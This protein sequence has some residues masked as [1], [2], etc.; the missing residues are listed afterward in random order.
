MIKA[1]VL[2]NI[3]A[4]KEKEVISRI[5]GVEGVKEVDLAFGKYDIIIR[6]EAVDEG[7]LRSAV[8]DSIRNIPDVLSTLT[9]ITYNI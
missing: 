6:V 8:I 3:T 1:Y 7:Q 2:G 9:L 5:E 4:N